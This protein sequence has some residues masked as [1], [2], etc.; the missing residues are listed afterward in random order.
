MEIRVKGKKILVVSPNCTH[1]QNAG[2]RARIYTMLKNLKD[3][4]HEIHFLYCGQEFTNK[5]V[6]RKPDFGG[7]IKEWDRVYQIS[8]FFVQLPLI[9]KNISFYSLAGNLWR[10]K[11]PFVL[12]RYFC[13]KYICITGKWMKVYTPTFYKCLKPFFPDKEQRQKNKVAVVQ[14][15]IRQQEE[16]GEKNKIAEFRPKEEPLSQ[17]DMWYNLKTD[18]LVRKL[19]AEHKYDVVIAEYVF[20]SRVLNNFGDDVLKIIDTHDIFTDRNKKYEQKGIKE[21]FFSTTKEEEAKGL[22]RADKIIAIQE[23]EAQ[24]FRQITNKEV[25]TIGHPVGLQRPVEKQDTNKNILY[26]GTGNSANIDGINDFIKDC[27][28]SIKNRVKGAQLI[29]AGNICSYVDDYEGVIKM[30]EVKD[31]HDAYNQADIVINPGAVGT[32]LK[33]KNIEALGL[34]KILITHSHSAEGLKDNVKNPFIVADTPDEIANAIVNVMSNLDLYNDLMVKAYEFAEEYNE[35]QISALTSLLRHHRVPIYEERDKEIIDYQMYN[36]Q[37]DEWGIRLRGPRPPSLK[38]GEYIA[39][40]G[41]AQT[42]GCYCEEPFPQILQD[43][44]G[45]S[46]MNLGWSGPGPQFFLNDKNLMNYI[47][48]SKFVV[49]QVMSAMGEDSSIAINFK[50]TKMLRMKSNGQHFLA[51]DFYDKLL[52]ENNKSYVKKIIN[53]TRNTW[54]E[55]YKVLLS[56]IKVPVILFW[57]ADREPDYIDKYGSSRSLFGGFP[58]LV[59]R[60]MVEEIRPCV[61]DYVECVSKRG[62]PQPLKSKLPNKKPVMYKRGKAIEKTYNNYYPS[63][64][65]QEDAANILE[66]ICNKYIKEPTVNVKNTSDI[67]VENSGDT[68]NF[69]I[70]TFP[71]TGST[72]LRKLLDLHPDISCAHE[73]FN[74]DLD[75]VENV[76]N[77]QYK[78]EDINDVERLN[79]VLDNIFKSYNCIKHLDLQLPFELNEALLK[80]PNSKVIFLWR[81]NLLQRQI[82]NHISMQSQHWQADTSA[83]LKSKLK[84][85]KISRLEKGINSDLKHIKEYRDYLS[86]NDVDFY[87]LAYE[88]FYDLDLSEDQKLEKLNQLFSYLGVDKMEDEQLIKKAKDLFNPQKTK[89]N[90]ELTYKLIPNIELIEQKIGCKETG[91]IFKH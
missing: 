82:S 22:N 27:L 66:P 85:I 73:P 40:V 87:E 90:S 65:M 13:I 1:P 83:I 51:R 7:M 14:E 24:F 62:M 28:P 89:L 44:L 53:E 60:D 47:N 61:Q 75:H 9:F 37:N 32:G 10:F 88:D 49:L 46:V 11:Q 78:L 31:I 84:P 56:Q 26:L 17:I 23:K 8:P 30:G 43:K 80:Y 36:L 45:V 34:G 19:H 33:I 29:L 52:K 16:A 55:K 2:N 86:S 6:K 74:E 72:T 38:K 59:N 18:T 76:T 48:N 3:M 15:R 77:G 79:Y 42:F 58:Q 64:E 39:C 70:F 25:I 91:Y 41:A 21:T 20:E 35:K 81:K 54:I 12:F 67:K 71:R 5:H 63:P 57:F 50:G 68:K 4:G 69:I